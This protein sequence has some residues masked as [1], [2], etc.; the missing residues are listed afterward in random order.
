MYNGRI[1][2]SKPNL[3]L[4]R[5]SAVTSARWTEARLMI[6]ADR[7]DEPVQLRPV[8]TFDAFYEREY[9]GLV[10]LAHALTGSRGHAEDVAQEAML[11]AYPS[12]GRGCVP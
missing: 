2:R 8:E 3:L 9:H 1:E 6:E 7:L 4:V 11:A 12:L 5:V 10:A